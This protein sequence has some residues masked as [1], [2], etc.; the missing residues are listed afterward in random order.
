MPYQISLFDGV[1]TARLDGRCNPQDL[2]LEIRGVLD[3]QTTPIVMIIDMTLAIGFDQQLKSMLY[4]MLQHHYISMVG[5]CGVNSMLTKDVDEVVPVLRRLRR[6]VIAE[7]EADLRIGLGL[8][9][10]AEPPRKLT[11]MLAYLKKA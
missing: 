5:I 10:T 11:G 4:R 8:A 9:P 2:Y 3:K 6:V 7:T 1:L